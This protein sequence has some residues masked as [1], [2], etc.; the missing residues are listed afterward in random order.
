MPPIGSNRVDDAGVALIREWV[1]SLEDPTPLD[2]ASW[3]A[4]FLSAQP[5]L[6]GTAD[7]DPDRD[8]QRNFQEF[9]ADTH[10]G[11]VGDRW[12]PQI[13]G[14]FL[15]LPET[16][17]GRLEIQTSVDVADWSLLSAEAVGSTS[18]GAVQLPLTQEGYRR[19]FR[20][21]MLADD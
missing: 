19:F 20:F 18:H 11:D 7:A 17:N 13:Q 5:A 9:I 1:N 2:Y 16:P 15:T 12:R 10:P 3:I 8:G 6:N 21:R 14:G 4:E